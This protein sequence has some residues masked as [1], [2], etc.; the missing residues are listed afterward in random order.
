MA[1]L[2]NCKCR[3]ELATVATM[4]TMRR[5]KH[6]PIQVRELGLFNVCENPKD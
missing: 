4:T 6:L 5:I 2:S 3:I 1:V